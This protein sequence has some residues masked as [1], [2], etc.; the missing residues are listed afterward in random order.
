M[1][2]CAHLIDAHE[3]VDRGGAWENSAQVAQCF[4]QGFDRPGDADHKEK[5][6]AQR[7]EQKDGGLAPLEPGADELCEEADR[8]DE[9]DRH[10]GEVGR[11]P[12]GREAV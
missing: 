10:Q 8:K 2:R 9:R 7:D 1:K 4:G 12:E 6:Q 3:A 5:R 11:S